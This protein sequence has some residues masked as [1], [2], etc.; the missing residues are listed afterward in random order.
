MEAENLP[1]LNL[2]NS[3]NVRIGDIVL[4]IGNPLGIGQTV[5]RELSR[6]K[7]VGQD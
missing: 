2:G 6:L 3:D 5:T 7:V 1:S 4:A